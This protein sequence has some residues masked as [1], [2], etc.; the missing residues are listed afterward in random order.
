MNAIAAPAKSGVRKQF[1]K[2]EIDSEKFITARL[3]GQAATLLS[4][5]HR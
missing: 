3:I 4:M 2:M 1:S 5:L